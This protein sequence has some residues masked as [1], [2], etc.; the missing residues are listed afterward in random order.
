[1][2]LGGNGGSEKAQ[3]KQT[4]ARNKKAYLPYTFWQQAKAVRDG[5]AKWREKREKYKNTKRPVP[6]ITVR[7]GPAGWLRYQSIPCMISNSPSG[8]PAANG[9]ESGP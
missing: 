5:R 7:K 4:E 2:I 3:Y 1:M 6:V 8:G 9:F